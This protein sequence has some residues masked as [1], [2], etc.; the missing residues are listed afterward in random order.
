MADIKYYKYGM[1]IGDDFYHI[2]S[3]ILINIGKFYFDAQCGSDN[4]LTEQIRQ[5]IIQ[6]RKNGYLSY[7]HA[8]LEICYDSGTNSINSDVMNK[9]MMAV[10]TLFVNCPDEEVLNHKPQ[11][12]PFCKERTTV[13]FNSFFDCK[14]PK[15]AFSDAID[16]LS[17]FYLMYLYYIKIYHLAECQIKPMEKVKQLYNYMIKEINCFMAHEFLL[18]QM[19]FIGWDK[20]KSIADGILKFGKIRSGKP[21]IRLLTNALFDI[22]IYR[23]MTMMVDIAMKEKIPLNCTFV[24]QD[25][26]LQNYIEMNSEFKTVINLDKISNTFSSEF[27]PDEKYLEEWNDF[28][29]NTMMVNA[30]QRF[31]E[32]QLSNKITVDKEKILKEINYYEDI[33][34]KR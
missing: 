29:S 31:M 1:G 21:A 7:E 16:S 9:F 20:E 30:K 26:D 4:V 23:Q 33:V 8:L 25:K 15:L 2:D 3:N 19:V 32:Y 17:L 24:T 28:Y 22:M 14:L 12:I 10:D 6:C 5:F 18:G 27:I 11:I 34:F 13:D